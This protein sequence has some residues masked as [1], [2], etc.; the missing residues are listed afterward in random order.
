[1]SVSN[2]HLG[3]LVECL[4]INCTAGSGTAPVHVPSARARGGCF[5]LLAMGIQEVSASE[6]WPT[7]GMTPR[8]LGLLEMLLFG[9][10]KCPARPAA[11]ID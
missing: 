6:V 1:M 9:S 4:I 3:R 11:T 7:A 5:I 10:D 8:D 2:D